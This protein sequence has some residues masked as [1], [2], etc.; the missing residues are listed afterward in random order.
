MLNEKQINENQKKIIAALRSTK[1]EGIDDLVSWLEKSNFFS[2]PA[3]TMFHGNFNGGLAAHSYAVYESFA[4]KV[5]E[6]SLDVPKESSI[7]AGICHDFCKI[8]VYV[9]N[10][11]KG[12]KLSEAKPYKIEEDFPIG[13]G[14][15]SII[16]IGKYISL[17]PQESVLIRWHM[18]I[19]DKS[20]EDYKSNI[21]EKYPETILFQHADREVSLFQKL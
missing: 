16:M 1:R 13:H 19:Y 17:K 4:K 10:L 3:S 20:W 2:S 12:G 11:L 21:E 8:G 7:L 5:E 9:P 18:G 15:K 6:Y 14:E